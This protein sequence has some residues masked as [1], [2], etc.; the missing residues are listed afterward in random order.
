MHK[1]IAIAATLLL[2]TLYA[3]RAGDWDLLLECISQITEYSFA[4]DNIN[5]RRYL[6]P[7]LA[8]M[9]YLEKIW[10]KKIK[11]GTVTEV[12]E[13]GAAKTPGQKQKKKES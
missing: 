2:N 9:V 7:F 3:N 11:A 6:L 13:N 5:Y 10:K 12:T 1:F 4:N 8:E